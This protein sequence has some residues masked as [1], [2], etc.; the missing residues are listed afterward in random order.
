MLWLKKGDIKSNWVAFSQSL[1]ISAESEPQMRHLI[2]SFIFL[3]SPVWAEEPR[4]FC[5]DT[6]VNHQWD[7]ALVKYPEDQLLL[8]LSAVRTT[9]CDMLSRNQIDLETARN[10]WEDALTDTLVE[11]ARNEQKKRGLLRLFGTF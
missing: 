3:A 11:W 7:E 2:I 10:A 8:N 4:N 9:L 1:I 6:E 5:S